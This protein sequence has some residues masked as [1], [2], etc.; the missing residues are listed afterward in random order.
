D[1]KEFMDL[2]REQ[3]NML[4]TRVETMKGMIDVERRE[5]RQLNTVGERNRDLQKEIDRLRQMLAGL[6]AILQ[7]E[8][9]SQPRGR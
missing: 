6:D 2:M 9:A 5:A 7:G 8:G 4:A 1:A 3:I